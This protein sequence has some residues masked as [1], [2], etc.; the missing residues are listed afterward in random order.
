M[1][2]ENK[3]LSISSIDELRKIANTLYDNLRAD[4][5]FCFKC[6]EVNNNYEYCNCKFLQM[7]IIFETE[8]IVT[9]IF[10]SQVD[11]RNMSESLI[12]TY[13][14][15][16]IGKVI[17]HIYERNKLVVF[18]FFKNKENEDEYNKLVSQIANVLTIKPDF[19]KNAKMIIEKRLINL[20]SLEPILL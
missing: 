6:V 12:S 16:E 1:S 11:F 9:E 20:I 15:V 17:K 8:S 4:E 10:Y 19:M 13:S 3:L 7:K 5:E 14:I 2:F 18:N